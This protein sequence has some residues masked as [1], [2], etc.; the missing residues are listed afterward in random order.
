LHLSNFS[1][2]AGRS[3]SQ[4][5]RSIAANLLLIW[6]LSTICTT[7]WAD[8]RSVSDLIAVL[9]TGDPDESAAAALSLGDSGAQ[10]NVAIDALV[11][12]LADRRFAGKGRG[13]FVVGDTVAVSASRALVIIGKPAVDRLAKCVSETDDE[14]ARTLALQTL[15]ELGQLASASAPNVESALKNDA[16]MIRYYAVIALV[17]VQSDVQRTVT[18]LRRILADEA[19]DVRAAAVRELGRF[20][21][22]AS[23]SI[24]D[25][26]R[27]LDDQGARSH[28][29][30]NHAFGTRLVRYDAAMAIARMGKA[31]KTALPKLELMMHDDKNPLV[32]VAAAFAVAFLDADASHAIDVLI[33]HMDDRKNKSESPRQAARFLGQLGAR[34]KSALPALKRALRHPDSLVRIFAADAI[35]AIDPVN[36]KSSL[37]V[38][39]GDDDSHVRSCVIDM[40]SDLN[41]AS[42]DVIAAY[43]AALDDQD[44][45]MSSDVRRCAIQALG[46]LGVKA[47]RAVPRLRVIA[48]KDKHTWA[49]ALALGLGGRLPLSHLDSARQTNQLI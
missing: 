8:E 24:P 43:I 27:L 42:P 23:S 32:Q 17:A 9:S 13:L 1:Q 2:Q 34:A 4:D 30:S 45:V 22:R 36:A 14:K 47:S 15:A 11:E 26:I 39:L 46:K 5:M 25:V 35:A 10:S 48:T 37:L 18:T 16:Y 21:T 31:A 44:D 40:L 20:E 33:A 29:Y 38:L 12:A 41:L 3:E 6:S 49:S 7:A 19:P 28:A